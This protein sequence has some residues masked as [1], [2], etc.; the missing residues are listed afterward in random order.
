MKNLKLIIN[1]IVITSSLMLFQC[2]SDYTAI[3]GQ[4]GID[5]VD[6]VDGLDGLDGLDGVGVQEC[7][8]CHS[9]SHREGIFD[10]YLTS[11]HGGQP[12][13]SYEAWTRG[14]RESCAPCHNNEG[15]IDYIETGAVAVG[16]YGISNPLNCN[17]CHDDHRSFDFEKDGNDYAV[18]TLDAVEFRVFAENDALPDYVLDYGNASNLCANCHQPRRGTPIADDYP[19]K[20][21]QTSGHWGPHHGP[22]TALLEGLLGAYTTFTLVEDIPAVKQAAH[23]TDTAAC[24]DC[25]MRHTTD[26]SFG[27][28]WNPTR[29]NCTDC[30]SGN[31]QDL[32]VAGLE[33]DMATLG[34]LLE[35]VVGQ[36]IDDNDEPIFEADGVTPVPVVG[37]VH[38]D[39]GDPNDPDDDE[40]HPQTGLFDL[41][42][43]EAAWNFLFI[44]EDR[45]HGIHNPNYAKSLIKN[46]IANLQ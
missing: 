19:G 15:F 30:H 18:R 23:R 40:W 8:D 7:I 11:G 24:I 3:P 25:H 9:T 17:G 10:A 5:G 20:Y 39:E 38:L 34:A 28:S 44:L 35:Q 29:N 31:A 14:T 27:H 45:S 2:T 36:A 32:E 13:Y 37:I 1:L 26:G 16:G 12:G 6:G 4:D 42:D 43:A 46:S 41:K 33:E 21:L 22:Q